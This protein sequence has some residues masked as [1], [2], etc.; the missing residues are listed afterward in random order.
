MEITSLSAMLPGLQGLMTGSHHSRKL[1]SS[2]TASHSS[3]SPQ[4]TGVGWRERMSVI[5]F[6]P[7]RIQSEEWRKTS[8]TWCYAL[9]GPFSISH[10]TS[11][12]TEVPTFLA[13]GTT[14]MAGGSGDG[15]GMIQAHYIYCA[16]YS[17]YYC[18]SSTSD[19]QALD[20]RGWGPL[21]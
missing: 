9:F 16:L 21:S 6:N 7:T 18:I 1:G 13:P 5:G 11:Q 20:P 3:L 19:H 10:R 2:R 4:A 17:Y 14:S 12:R 8:L 15:L